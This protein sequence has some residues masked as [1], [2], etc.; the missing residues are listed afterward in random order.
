MRKF[1]G[2]NHVRSYEYFI[3]S[4][5]SSCPFLAISCSSFKVG[6]HKQVSRSKLNVCTLQDF[7]AGRCFQCDTR[8]NQCVQFGF[9]SIHSYNK[10]VQRQ[11]IQ[12]DQRLVLY[13]M[14]GAE[15]PY[16]SKSFSRWLAMLIDEFDC[17]QGPTTA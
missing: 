17:W 3:E 9:H 5:A 10:L 14:T 7:K 13:F 6:S 1:L 16:C 15:S 11:M 8:D 12:P 2:C 4:V